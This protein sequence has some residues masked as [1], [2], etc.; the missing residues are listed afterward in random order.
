MK[1]VVISYIKGALRRTWGRSKQRKFALY[2]AKVEYG[3]YRCAGCGKIYRR[4]E[5]E[6]DHIV[7]VGKFVDFDTYIEKLF[8]DSDKLAVLCKNC[9]KKKTRKDLR[10][11]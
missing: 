8:C 9:H 2:N 4:R 5:I 3:K 6:V 1:K 10:K 7:A 11:I